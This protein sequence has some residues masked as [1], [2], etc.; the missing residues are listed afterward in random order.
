MVLLAIISNK[1]QAP[2]AYSTGTIQVRWAKYGVQQI[3]NDP[4]GRKWD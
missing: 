1:V 4:S 2:N 3:P